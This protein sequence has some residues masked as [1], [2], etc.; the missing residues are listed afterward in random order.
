M[1]NKYF[2]IYSKR[3]N[4][5]TVLLLFIS[6][7]IL[8]GYVNIQLFEQPELKNIIETHGYKEKTIVGNRGKITDRNNKELAITIN[9]YTFW[10]NTTEKYDKKNIIKLFSEVF[11]KDETF[12]QEKLSQESRYIPIEKNVTDV[13][14]DQILTKIK[15][16]DGLRF[17][18][19]PSRLYNYK[20]FACQ[21]IGYINTTG[22]GVLGIEKSCNHLLKGD[23]T[24]IT[25]RKGANGKYFNTE[26]LDENEI[27]GSNIQI[28]VDIELQRILQEELYKSMILTEAKGA[29]GIIMDPYTGE[30][31]AIAS[32]PDF[33]PNNY[34]EFDIATYNNSVISDSYE[35]GSTLKIIPFAFAIQYDNYNLNDS[36]F[37]ENGSY[38]LAN[39]RMLNDHEEHGF[40]SLNEILIHSS[41]IGISK[42]SDSFNKKTFYKFI[43]KFG[44]GSRTYLPLSNESEGKIRN[45]SEWS[46]TS[47]NYIS[48][49]QEIAITNL[50]LATAYS[51]IANGGYLVKPKII[52]NIIKNNDIS[53]SNETTTIRKILDTKITKDILETLK[54]V[55]SD[56]TAKS[57]NLDG[58]NIAGK[59]GTAQK[60]ENGA[61]SKFVSTFASIFPADNPKYVMIVSI[62]EPIHGKHWSNLSAVPATREIIK[63]MIILNKDFHISTSDE[64]YLDTNIDSIDILNKNHMVTKGEIP[65]FRGMSLRESFKIAELVGLR[66]NPIG[67]SG[68]VLKQSIPPGT[69]LKSD[70]VCEIIVKI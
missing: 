15:E 7:I 8:G 65:D 5:M 48:I 50:Q 33:D 18:K 27:N 34:N 45:I 69:K 36:I 39:N 67:I 4:R 25:L 64:F 63:R 14:A 60:F 43:K 54:L 53:Y 61:Y 10:V 41:N 30:I 70:M 42:I 68:T 59:T 57:I 9:K 21:T 35:P 62:D 17:D 47:K 26:I 2:E 11:N 66:L 1:N 23:T 29:N 40:L 58:Y 3:M 6:T 31:I 22:I 16:F 20:N 46:K 49:G 28:T 12:Y 37:C 56:G 51:S 24:N 38:R 52:K 32:V 44:L 13:K 19:N 55:V